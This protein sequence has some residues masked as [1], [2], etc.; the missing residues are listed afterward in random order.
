MEY[1]YAAAILHELDQ[2]INEPNM[3]AVL[4]AAGANVSESQVKALIAAL[5]GVDLDQIVG[6]AQPALPDDGTEAQPAGEMEAAEDGQAEAEGQSDLP[7]TT[8]EEAE[9]D[10]GGSLSNIFGGD[11]DS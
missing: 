11:D 4:E 10:S 6:A 9:G 2:E 1:V 3:K 7:E 5:E 8:E